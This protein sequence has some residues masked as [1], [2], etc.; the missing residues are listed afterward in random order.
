M[1][2]ILDPF[3]RDLLLEV[4]SIAAGKSIA[5]ITNV[6]GQTVT[7]IPPRLILDHMEKIADSMGHP[8]DLKTVVFIRIIGDA[9]GAVV[10]LI[11][12]E[13]LNILLPH[14]E[15][16]L[17]ISALEEITNIISGASLG[18]LSN[19]LGLEL[20]Q[21]TPHSATD[22][23][24]AVVNEIVTE[25]GI[26]NAQILCFA[27]H[28]KVGPTSVPITLYMMF[29]DISSAKILESGKKHIEKNT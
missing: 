2:M 4:A 6:T 28:L 22:M 11:D 9:H 3:E 1:S 23:L 15:N 14:I 17:K 7:I 12:P 8:E 16:N 20:L 19:F 10:L 18:G 24:R 13:N 26:S 27:I 21:S 5:P 29:D 25:V